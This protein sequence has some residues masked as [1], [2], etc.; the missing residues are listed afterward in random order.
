M[1]SY[2]TNGMIKTSIILF[3]K[4]NIRSSKSVS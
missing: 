4:L 2:C 3:K 1:N